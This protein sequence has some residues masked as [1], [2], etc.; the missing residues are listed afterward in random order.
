MDLTSHVNVAGCVFQPL[1]LKALCLVASALCQA[2]S[3]SQHLC[4][5]KGEGKGTFPLSSRLIPPCQRRDFA[6][7]GVNKK[8][9]QSLKEGGKRKESGGTREGA[10]QGHG[11]PGLTWPLP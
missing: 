9:A 1:L 8:T 2:T 10:A 11:A 3:G 5:G 4:Q 7:T 6:R